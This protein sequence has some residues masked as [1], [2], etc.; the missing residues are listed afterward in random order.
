MTYL[1]RHE[2]RAAILEAA[3]LVVMKEG[4]AAATVRRIAHETGAA[5]GQLHHHFRSASELRAEAF[6]TLTRRSFEKKRKEHAGKDTVTRLMALLGNSDSA[7]ELRENNLWNEAVLISQHD[8]AMK[9]ALDASMT[10]WH[11]E[12]FM[13]LEG[14]R[15]G[16]LSADPSSPG[17]GVWRLI[18]LSNGL[19][20]LMQLDAARFSKDVCN[21]HLLIAIERELR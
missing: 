4:L 20:S 10:M 7:T 14:E 9:A 8:E 5:T 3:V 6:A 17:D 21:R 18:A 19:Y 15:V 16:G 1:A 2:R 13:V 12:I 11:Q